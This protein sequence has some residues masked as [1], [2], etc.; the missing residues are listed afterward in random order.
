MFKYFVNQK[1]FQEKVE[2]E[3]RQLRM[4]NIEILGTL[5]VLYEAQ[6]KRVF[7]KKIRLG[8]NIKAVYQS[9]IKFKS[10]FILQILSEC[11]EMRPEDLLGKVWEIN[12][13]E[14]ISLSKLKARLYYLKSIGKVRFGKGKGTFAIRKK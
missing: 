6:S 10:N 5:K 2:C 8:E 7:A 13:Q 3:I 14:N 9:K 11:I 12:R 1:L 4:E